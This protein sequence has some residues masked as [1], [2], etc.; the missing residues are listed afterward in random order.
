MGKKKSKSRIGELSFAGIIIISII[1]A[2]GFTG[3][4][5]TLGRT[6]LVVFGLIAGI[7]N[8]KPVEEI[9]FLLSMI[10]IDAGIGMA[11]LGVLGPLSGFFG[12]LLSNLFIGFGVMTLVVAIPIVFRSGKD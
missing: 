10:A 2:L 7:L 12:L 4:Y 9:K 5:E 3:T 11:L 8:I 6:L 1:A